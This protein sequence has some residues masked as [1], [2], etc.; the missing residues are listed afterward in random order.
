MKKSF[1]LLCLCALGFNLPAQTNINTIVLR[2]VNIISMTGDERI[3]RE[4]DIVIKGDRIYD[5]TD[6]KKDKKYRKWDAQ[7]VD[8]TGKFVM[9]GLIDMHAHLPGPFG[10]DFDQD[11]Y[12]FLNLAN[13]VTSLRDMR[14][15]I[16]K[17]QLRKTYEQGS[18]LSPRLFLASPPFT[19]DRNYNAYVGNILMEAYKKDGFDFI[20][21]L[22]GMDKDDYTSFMSIA[23]EHKMDVVGHTPK[24]GLEVAVNAGQRS[25]EH[26]EPFLELYR[27]DKIQF[28]IVMQKM[29]SSGIYSCP[30]LFWYFPA[31]DQMGLSELKA[32]RGFQYVTKNVRDQWIDDIEK[33]YAVDVQ[34]DPV[35]FQQD[36]EQHLNDI[37]LF[38]FIFKEM[39][40]IG[41]P[42]LLGGGDG[43]FVIPGFSMKEEMQLYQKAGISNYDILKAGTVNA[44]ECMKINNVGTVEIG[45]Y[46][47][48]LLL[49]KNPIRDLKRLDLIE[50][51]ILKGKY[52]TKEEINNRLEEIRKTNQ[53]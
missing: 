27:K 18:K 52:I 7:L 45:K 43:Y 10:G 23:K 30:T 22:G 49:E 28:K 33:Y 8:V 26:I 44:A 53:F 31:W 12:F 38:L 50:W 40:E 17:V 11:E 20:K 25:I 5:I 1:V 2:N 19:Y 39:H 46:A 14:G 48:L 36:K 6:K 24:I 32:L 13:G 51:V 3:D 29:A 37:A 42:L 9:P 15:T 35:T 41:V 21:Y 34:K 16:E 47:D 4:K